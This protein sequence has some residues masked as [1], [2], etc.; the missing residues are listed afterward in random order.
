MVLCSYNGRDKGDIGEG[1]GCSME[2]RYGEEGYVPWK[3]MRAERRRWRYAL[4]AMITILTSK[5]E[6][7]RNRRAR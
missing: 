6:S 7:K 5:S 2:G 3:A 1:E 4:R